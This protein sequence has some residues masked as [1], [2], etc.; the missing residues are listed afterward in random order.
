MTSSFDHPVIF[1]WRL[2][3]RLFVALAMLFTSLFL[4]AQPVRAADLDLAVDPG[5]EAHAVNSGPVI[6][7]EHF[8]D[9]SL[10]RWEFFPAEQK[11]WQ[12]QGPAP[13]NS[14]Q[15][16]QD[17]QIFTAHL[18]KGMTRS[19]VVPKTEFWPEDLTD[20]DFSFQYRMTAGV[21]TNFLFNFRDE[22]N[23]YEF[24]LKYDSYQLVRV[25][26]GRVT[27]HTFGP[28]KFKSGEWHKIT[29]RVYQDVIQLYID[30]Q[31]I[32][33]QVD[34][35]HDQHSQGRAGLRATTGLVF[36]T[37]VSYAHLTVREILPAP[38]AGSVASHLTH[39]FQ[40]D[41]RWA[42]AEYDQAHDWAAKYQESDQFDRWGCLVTSLAMILHFHSLT[43]LP[44]GRLLQ[45]GTLN[46]WLKEQPDGFLGEGLVNW[47]A[48]TR[49]SWQISQQLGTPKLEFRAE[50][51]SPMK[52]AQSALA[53]QE[54]VILQLPGHFLVGTDLIHNSQDIFLADPFFGQRRLD[55]HP[56]QPLISTRLLT[57]S[58]TDLSYLLIVHP[59]E[60]TVELF[61]ST[62]TTQPISPLPMITVADDI[63]PPDSESPTGRQ[64][65]LPNQA[66]LLQ[67]YL[68]KPTSGQYQLKLSSQTP[69]SYPIS[70]Y[71]YDQT[72]SVS[73]TTEELWL[74]SLPLTLTIEYQKN[75]QSPSTFHFV[76]P[77][78]TFLTEVEFLLERYAQSLPDQTQT[79]MQALLALSRQPDPEKSQIDQY[80]HDQSDCL[81]PELS[82][83]L[84]SRLELVQ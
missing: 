41:A 73:Q 10:N 13:P 27:L 60:V 79:V 4:A 72:A 66:Q 44:D 28:A 33:S 40:T 30:E 39:W 80:L 64:P 61:E 34:W 70:V 47:L 35:T 74:H 52:A 5:I 57:P 15:P 81:S 53:R 43:T 21:D 7:Q 6:F 67:S 46:D 42:S 82:H 68:P 16:F 2:I 8:S 36:P 32:A 69:A 56:L 55:Q 29:I 65:P 48:I 63:F 12:T 75:P 1:F 24:H 9:D 51:N 18:P 23:W 31:L 19:M 54:P 11:W 25:E 59:P 3:A 71:A 84:K 20:Y 78:T 50:T 45:P 22:A 62:Q 38:P 83:F 26:D 76:Y 58:Q 14:D 49:L 17:S 37:E 77:L